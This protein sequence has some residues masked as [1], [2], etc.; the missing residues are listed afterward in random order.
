MMPGNDTD[1]ARYA[2]L[3]IKVGLNL[4]AGQR[5]LLYGPVQAVPLMRALTASAYRR[6]A[7]FVDVIFDDQELRLIRHQY[8]PRDS[9]EEHPTWLGE[10]MAR[11]AERG[12]AFLRVHAEDPDLLKAQDP[13]QLHIEKMTAD[14]YMNPF[15][16]LLSRNA[17]NW[18]LLSQP[19]AGW[20]SKVFPGLPAE[21]R[22]ARL[23]ELIFQ[24]TRMDDPDPVAAWGAHLAQLEQRAAR[25]N[26]E[27]YA[28]LEFSGPGTQL[29]VGLAY[30][31]RWMGGQSCTANGITFTPNL[32][33]E[34]IFTIPHRERT[35]GVVTASRPLDLDGTLIED[36]ALTFRDG[37]VVDVTARKAEALLRKTIETDEG[38]ARLGEVALV[39]ASNPIARSGVLFYNTLFDENAASHLALGFGYRFCL[40]RGA[41][42]SDE[43][44]QDAGG[45]YS[46]I[47]IDFMIGSPEI[48]VDGVHRDGR[49]EPLL[50]RGE[51]VFP[52]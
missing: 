24:V 8:A 50:R 34:E 22:E 21:E 16:Q 10:T 12:D 40:E 15:R 7:R 25:L 48:E 14:R 37:R 17:F 2:E 35:E 49:R 5:L 13:A 42:L 9:F 4:Q 45:N 36:F 43:E 52:V 18:T 41:D 1:L 11:Y 38:A 51:W 39:P 23:W 32:P 26:R 29:S 30:G 3:A 31:H 33:T 46:L 20:A 19:I 28:A 6:G 44:F 47:H 27:N